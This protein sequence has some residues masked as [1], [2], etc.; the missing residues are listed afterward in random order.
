MHE[1]SLLD[2]AMNDAVDNIWKEFDRRWA[3]Q[4]AKWDAYMKDYREWEGKVEKCFNEDRDR[5]DEAAEAG[6]M[7][8]ASE[9][10]RTK[11]CVVLALFMA[12]LLLFLTFYGKP[13]HSWLES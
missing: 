10:K 5:E 12:F 11:Q 8:V 7:K 2:V 6:R 3:F 1:A 9:K 4:D 13:I